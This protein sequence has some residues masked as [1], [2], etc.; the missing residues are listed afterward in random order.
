VFLPLQLGLVA[1]VKNLVFAVA[2]HL[3]EQVEVAVD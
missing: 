3:M 2:H 1:M